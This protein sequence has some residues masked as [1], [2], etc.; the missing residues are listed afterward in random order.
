[1]SGQ[2]P[3][4]HAPTTWFAGAEQ[5][6]P[7]D[8]GS[9]YLDAIRFALEDELEADEG[10]VL[11]GE[12]IGVMGGAFRATEGLHARFG[13]ERVMDTP[14]AEI[15]IVGAAIGMAIS[16]LRPIV[17]LQFADFVSCAYDQLVTEAAKLHYRWGIAVPMVVRLPSGG[18]LGA[19]PFHSQSPE[20]VF[21]HIPGL[22]VVAPGTVQDAYDL[23]RAAVADPNPVLFFE[24]KALYRSLRGP[25][26]RRRPEQGLGSAAVARAGTQVT[27]ATYGGMVPRCLEAAHRLAAEGID[28]EVLDLR[29][30]LPAD[31]GAVA[32][33]VRRTGRLVVVHEDTLT[34]GI[35]AEVAARAAADAFFH[36]DAPIAR[37]AAPDCPVPFALPLEEAYVPTVD[38]IADA[39]RATAAA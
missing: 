24:H 16:G 36:L 37:V 28:A 22:K 25:L 8:R 13:P 18:G 10:V 32:D 34:S 29:T 19:G 31:H 1:V 39:I 15:A 9:T 5:A 26:E 33:S 35:G 20:G 23:L 27:V 30:L 12:D 4:T 7:E 11:L 14:I 21:A 3:T 17:E 38:R 6:A 2:A